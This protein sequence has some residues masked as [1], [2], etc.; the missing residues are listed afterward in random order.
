MHSYGIKA[1]LAQCPDRAVLL[2]GLLLT[3]AA[4]LAQQST[5]EDRQRAAI[6]AQVGP[7]TARLRAQLSQCDSKKGS[8][9][10]CRDS[11]DGAA[12]KRFLTPF[13]GQV[14]AGIQLCPLT[15]DRAQLG[16]GLTGSFGAPGPDPGP[17]ESVQVNYT[18]PRGVVDQSVVVVG[19]QAWLVRWSV[20][21]RRGARH[22]AAWLYAAAGIAA[23][24]LL[25]LGKRTFFPFGADCTPP[26]RRWS[27]GGCDSFARSRE[28]TR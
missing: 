4:C 12:C 23:S 19:G 28:G 5:K 15:L 24:G 13:S 14:D 8:G 17:E 18:G 21:A 3:W 25:F 7:M 11:L 10:F 6:A 20:P 22:G 16:Q 26:Q 2:L 9:T 1:C 27:S